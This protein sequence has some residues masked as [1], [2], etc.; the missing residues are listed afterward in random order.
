MIIKLER[1]VKICQI[2]IKIKIMYVKMSF[3]NQNLILKCL[4]IGKISFTINRSMFSFIK[5]HTNFII[6]VYLFSKLIILINSFIF[7][8]IYFKIKK[9][10][11]I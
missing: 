7:S 8:K 11:I 5:V 9:S 10:K 3:F 4:Y 6:S 2:E 1:K